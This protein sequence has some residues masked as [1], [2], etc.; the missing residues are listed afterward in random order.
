MVIGH[1]WL[2]GCMAAWMHGCMD[3]WSDWNVGMAPF[4][5]I[6]ACGGKLFNPLQELLP[7]QSDK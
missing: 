5:Q 7:S 3:A 1:W 4:G 6:N 2:Y